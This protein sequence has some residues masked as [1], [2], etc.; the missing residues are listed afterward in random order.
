MYRRYI[1]SIIIIIIIII[2][3]NYLAIQYKNNE[4]SS[5][6]ST[7]LQNTDGARLLD[8]QDLVSIG[9]QFLQLEPL[10]EVRTNLERS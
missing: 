4:V 1:K 3:I 6:L 9:V 5:P 8:F 10:M 7:A 2:I